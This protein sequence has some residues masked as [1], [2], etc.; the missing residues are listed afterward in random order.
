MCPRKRVR[1]WRDPERLE[2][3]ARLAFTVI[4]IVGFF[5]RHF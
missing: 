3:V 4:Q 5:T 2:K 1:W